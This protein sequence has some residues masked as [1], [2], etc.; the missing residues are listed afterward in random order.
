LCGRPALFRWWC[1]RP[2]LFRWCD[3][4]SRSAHSRRTIGP[5]QQAFRHAQQE[6][7]VVLRELGDQRTQP[8]SW[9]LLAAHR[10]RFRALAF[11][12]RVL[13]ST[14]PWGRRPTRTVPSRACRPFVFLSHRAVARSVPHAPGQW[15]RA[16]Q[17][18]RLHRRCT[19]AGIAMPRERRREV[20]GPLYII[21]GCQQH[22]AA[23]QAQIDVHAHLA[24]VETPACTSAWT[25]RSCNSVKAEARSCVGRPVPPR[26]WP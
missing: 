15:G 20:M 4:G 21:V 19:H 18:Q 24:L 9:V 26:R 14:S 8:C 16:G 23:H 22:M 25:T 17:L 11:D 1:G 6:F 12:S 10:V 7:D 13:G 3:A 2:A 5:G